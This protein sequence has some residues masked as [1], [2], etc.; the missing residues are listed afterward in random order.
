MNI[1]TAVSA[2]CAPKTH[3]FEGRIGVGYCSRPVRVGAAWSPVTHRAL[4]LHSDMA[5]ALAANN[6][7]RTPSDV[8][9]SE[10]IGPAEELV[11]SFRLS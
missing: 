1:R 2:A 3:Q 4:F 5:G 8:D 6:T 7:T 11:S 9:A 10:N